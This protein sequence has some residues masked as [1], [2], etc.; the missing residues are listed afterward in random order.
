MKTKLLQSIEQGCLETA[1]TVV[2]KGGIV[3]FPTD[4]VYGIGTT[5]FDEKAVSQ[6]FA[7]KD[8]S[9]ERAIPILVSDLAQ[10]DTLAEEIPTIAGRL[11]DAFWPGPLTVVFKKRNGVAASVSRTGTIGVRMPDHPF[12][13]ALI[14]SVGPMA[15][16]S[17]NL[18]GSPSL[19]SASEVFEVMKGKIEL[20]IDGGSTPG[21]VP[22]TVVDCTGSGPVILRQGPI[23]LADIQRVLRS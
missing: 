2:Q 7:V 13:R 18:A 5:A 19:C 10:L 4:T 1:A 14:N 20:V 6:M 3:A 21:G 17:A 9:K 11:I 22:S 12:V 15:V 23:T 16:T 8:R